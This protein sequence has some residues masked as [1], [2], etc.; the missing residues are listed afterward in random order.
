MW[1]KRPERLLVNHKAPRWLTA[2]CDLRSAGRPLQ[3]SFLA[4]TL[5]LPLVGTWWAR[6]ALGGPYAYYIINFIGKR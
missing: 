3:L 4:S 2:T 5:H 6:K 1:P